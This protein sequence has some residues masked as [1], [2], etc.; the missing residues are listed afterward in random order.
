V[1]NRVGADPV[2]YALAAGSHTVVIKQREDGTELDRI[3][4][5]NDLVYVPD[6]VGET[7]PVAPVT[8]SVPVTAGIV[9][10]LYTYDVNAIG[11]PAPT[12]GLAGTPPSGMTIDGSTGV[13]AWMPTETGTFD[14]TVEAVNTVGVAS[15]SFAV[16]V[17]AAA[18]VWVEAEAGGS[19]APMV[20]ASDGTASLGQYV[21]TPNGTGTVSTPSA[22]GGSVSV[23][24][25]VPMAGNYVVW[26]RVRSASG[27]DDSFW[28][29]M[30]AGAYALWDTVPGGYGVWGWDAVSH[31]GGANPVV[32]ALAAGSHTLVIKQRE[33]GAKLDRLV[34]TNDPLY[35][36]TGLGEPVP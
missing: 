28:V 20:V 7:V 27:E 11:E 19:V 31:R 23:T 16:T 3:L 30:D 17:G 12:Y 6:G 34:I 14:V 5:S 18:R 22:A 10:Q 4:I 32:Y 13:I 21:W 29:S 33:D 9:G 1:N 15:Q 25:S 36:P 35:V 2:V 8:T 26:G 24:F